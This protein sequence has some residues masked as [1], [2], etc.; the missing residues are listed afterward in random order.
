MHGRNRAGIDEPLDARL[1]GAGAQDTLRT[2]YLR[3]HYIL[4]LSV[5]PSERACH[6]YNGTA[7]SDC[8]IVCAWLLLVFNCH[9]LNSHLGIL[10]APCRGTLFR[11]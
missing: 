6:V 9:P 2:P 3:D 7:S 4:P 11:T 5:L 8:L 10:G 1:L